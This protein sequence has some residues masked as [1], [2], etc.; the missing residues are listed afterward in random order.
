MRLPSKEG[1]SE[2]CRAHSRSTSPAQARAASAG[3]LPA[4]TSRRAAKATRARRAVAYESDGNDQ[5]DDRLSA[6]AL[7]KQLGS[8]T[9]E[10]EIKKIKRC[11]LGSKGLTGRTGTTPS[12][13]P[14]SSRMTVP[15][16]RKW[17]KLALDA[18]LGAAGLSLLVPTA[19]S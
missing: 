11:S 15:I 3:E 13:Y 14:I 1:A 5:D 16:D 9:D 8:V 18:A 7:Q 17:L 19:H 12:F 2:R 4:E 6:E 10:N